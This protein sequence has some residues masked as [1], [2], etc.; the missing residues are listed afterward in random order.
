M[1]LNPPKFQYVLQAT[2]KKLSNRQVR[3]KLFFTLV[4]QV[5]LIG[6]VQSN[7]NMF[8]VYKATSADENKDI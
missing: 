2:G 6:A 5:V 8:I 1:R 4:R 3:G 7:V